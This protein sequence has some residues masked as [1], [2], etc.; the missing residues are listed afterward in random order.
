MFSYFGILYYSS[1]FYVLNEDNYKEI[2]ISIV[3]SLQKLKQLRNFIL[4]K[5]R[6][7]PYFLSSQEHFRHRNP[8]QFKMFLSVNMNRSN[9]YLSDEYL[10]LTVFNVKEHHQHTGKEP[11]RNGKLAGNLTG[12]TFQP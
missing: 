8:F 3:N 11:P 5:Y 10:N 4:Y 6:N 12:G 9:L 1:L 2:Q 7:S